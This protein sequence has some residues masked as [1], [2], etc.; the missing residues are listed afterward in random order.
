M[1]SYAKLQKKVN[2]LETKNVDE[3]IDSGEY[4]K[5][6]GEYV[7]DKVHENHSNCKVK[8]NNKD[9]ALKFIESFASLYYGS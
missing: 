3:F 8:F 6:R 2:A 7:F 5:L 1:F 4:H 9:F